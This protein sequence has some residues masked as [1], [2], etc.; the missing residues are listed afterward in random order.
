MFPVV[1]GVMRN[2]APRW[3]GIADVVVAFALV[4]QAIVI[5]KRAT[6]PDANVAAA[7]L[8]VV[9]SGANVFLGLIVVFFLAGHRIHWDVLLLGLAWRAWLF[10]WVLPSALTISRNEGSG[11]L[12]SP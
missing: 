7:G 2:P 3:I 8:R 5:M 4:V 11:Q 1:A 12:G 9:R 10:V 6:K